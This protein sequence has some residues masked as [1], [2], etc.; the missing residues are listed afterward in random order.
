MKIDREFRIVTPTTGASTYLAE[1]M[2]SLALIPRELFSHAF[3]CP[4]QCVPRLREAYPDS[5]AVP[6]SAPSMYAAINDGAAIDPTW[7]WMTY[8]N[9]DDYFLPGMA[10]LMDDVVSTL[11]PN[12]SVI[13]YSRAIFV[14]EAGN[15]ICEFPIMRQPARLLD[16]YS[17][18][19]NP[20]ATHGTIVSRAAFEM[21][22]GFDPEFRYAGDMDFFV[23]G[24]LSNV[25]FV[26]RPWVSTA[27]RLHGSNLTTDVANF[28]VEEGRVRTSIQKSI[29]YFNAKVLRARFMAENWRSYWDRW[30]TIRRFRVGSYLNE[31]SNEV[32]L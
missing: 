11:D 29:G 28:A 25:R 2:A 6:E 7:R 30:K 9:D 13:V 20:I 23:R 14:N 19:C 3:A 24:L 26:Y 31:L 1:T 4:F 32:G 10:R 5:L 8:I 22:G 15:W 21:L 18:A 17:I 12:E 27:F 16:C